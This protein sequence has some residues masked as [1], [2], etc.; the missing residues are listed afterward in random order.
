MTDE[1][2]EDRSADKPLDLGIYN[3]RV[4]ASGLSAAEMIALVLT[5]LWLAGV[6]VFFFVM[7]RGSEAGIDP[8]RTVMLLFAVFMPVALFWVA[9]LALNSARVMREE[10]SRL[11]TAIDAMRQTYVAQTQTAHMVRPSASV[12]RKLDQIMAAQSRQGADS[13]FA[14]FAPP[15]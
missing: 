14:T 12:E 15:R 2:P 3:R 6:T 4:S 10:A 9:A 5:V 7:G 8:L 13:A 11:Q 1:A